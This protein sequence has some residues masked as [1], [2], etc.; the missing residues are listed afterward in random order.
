MS[1]CSGLKAVDSD[2][3]MLRSTA[4]DFQLAPLHFPVCS[5]SATGSALNHSSHHNLE[6]L[7][8]FVRRAKL[9]D[10]QNDSIS[11]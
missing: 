5:C 6:F 2:R 10:G 9:A 1:G 7:I 11:T 4:P 3:S 8:S